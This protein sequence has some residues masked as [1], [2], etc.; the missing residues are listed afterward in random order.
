MPMKKNG[1]ILIYVAGALNSDAVGYIKNLRKLNS[2]SI[3]LRKLGFCTFVPGNDFLEGLIAGNFEY[4]DYF[5]NNQPVLDR[6]DGIFVT[7]HWENSEG[8]KKEI[9]RAESKK[10]PVFYKVEHLIKHFKK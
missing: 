7:P 1:D 2:W 6:S 9:K 4:R 8:T 3:R 10:V 5:E